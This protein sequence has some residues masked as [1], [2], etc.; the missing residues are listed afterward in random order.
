MTEQSKD[1]TVEPFFDKSQI[2]WSPW[3]KVKL[4]DKTAHLN[5]KYPKR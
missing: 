4:Q 5:T 2:T 1:K 3:G